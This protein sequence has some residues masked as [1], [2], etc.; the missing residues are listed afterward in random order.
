VRQ[1]RR[2]ASQGWLDRYRSGEREQVWHELRQ[3]GDRVRTDDLAREAQA[4]CDEMARRA[5]HNVEVLVARLRAQGFQFHT[6]DDSREPVAP[7]RSPTE[8]APSLDAWLR[9]RFGPIPMVV[10]SWIRIVGDVWLVGTH[11]NWPE[12]YEADALVIELEGAR[13]PDAS[14]RDYFDGEYEAW[15][16]C[17]A[18]DEDAAG[19]VLPV[20]PDRLHKANVSGGAPYGVRLP[21][22]TAE[23]L[24]VGE[25][26]MPFVAYLNLAFRHG[27][28]P[29]S[30]S[31]DQQWMIKKALAAG[32]LAL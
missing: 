26:A 4:V 8:Q 21:D 11:P 1:D 24:F 20:A 3:Y 27:G 15:Q 18:D 19:F 10:S 13:Y 28:F 30:V 14:I 22:G 31:G 29:G 5:L 9:D 2:V 17:S 25:V 12:S 32:L 6:N 23:G 16:E 7:H